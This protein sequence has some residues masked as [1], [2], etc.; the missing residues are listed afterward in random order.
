[1]KDHS[2]VVSPQQTHT[3][4]PGRLNAWNLNEGLGRLRMSGRT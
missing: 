1:M 4:F 3:G 2:G